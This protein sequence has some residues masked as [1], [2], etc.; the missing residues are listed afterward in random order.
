MTKYRIIAS[1]RMV[2]AIGAHGTNRNMFTIEAE[3]DKVNAAAIDEH[4]RLFPELE[5]VTIIR[6]DKI[7][8]Q[9]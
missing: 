1:S 8:V 4:Y 3:P 2:G 7:E 5:H 9:S 6:A